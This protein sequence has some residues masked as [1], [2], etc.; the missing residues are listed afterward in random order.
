MNENTLSYLM[1]LA[2]TDIQREIIELV[3]KMNVE[4]IDEEDIFR[5][6]LSKMEALD[7]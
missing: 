4:G 2:E 5:K 7:Q 3:S 6:L 1:G